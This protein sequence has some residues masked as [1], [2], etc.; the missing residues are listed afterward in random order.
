M[1]IATI[2][3]NSQDELIHDRLVNSL[4]Y[5]TQIFYK[6]RTGRK[7]DLS[8]PAGRESHFITICRELVKVFDGETK[9][10][11]INVAPRYGKSELVIHFVAW[12]MAQYPDSNFIYVSYAHSLAK[13]QTQTIRSI[14]Q[15]REYQELFGVRLKDDTSAKDNFETTKNGSVFAAGAGGSI[16]GR[17]AGI[18]NVN[19]FGGARIIDDI[20]KPNEAYSEVIRDGIKD[21]YYDTLVS[22]ANSPDTPT[23]FIGQRVHEDDLAAHLLKEGGWKL[24]ELK[25]LDDSGNA[26]Y[27]EMHKVQDLKEMETISPY[28][29]AAQHQQNPQPAGGGIFKPDWFVKYDNEPQIIATFITCDSAETEKS[30]NDATVFSF[31]GIYKTRIKDVETDRYALHWLDCWE[32]RIE[33]KDLENEFLN[34]YSQCMMHRIKPSLVAI[35]KKSTGITLI[36]TLKGYQGLRIIEI[37]RNRTSGS[38]ID[39]FI[40]AQPYVAQRLISLPSYG[41]HTD[42]CIKHCKG[43]TANN[44][45]RFDDIADTMYDAIKIALIDK[46]VVNIQTNDNKDSEIARNVMGAFSRLDQLR[47]KAYT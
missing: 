22:R 12:A 17:G 30:Y 37:E 15:L 43:I 45:H 18:K 9:K 6:I 39:R 23:I 21:W 19:R 1:Q 27:P 7:F 2:N 44:S 40:E 11:M 8:N 10:L 42:K 13:R 20:H 29:F 4:L 36:S 26:L 28:F 24:V 35:E 14:M 32:L 46:T 25:S 41:S 5:F 3:T 31:W 38:K 16:T 33:P 47:K 34:F